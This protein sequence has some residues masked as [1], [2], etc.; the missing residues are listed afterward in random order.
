MGDAMERTMKYNTKTE[1]AVKNALLGLLAKKPLSDVTVSELARAAGVSRS[2][3]YEHYGNPCDVYDDLM[4]EMSGELSPLM[5][6]VTCKDGFKAEGTP[7]CELVRGEGRYA[8]VVG[9]ARFIDT[10]LGQ[11]VAGEGHDLYG[12]LVDA[13]YSCEQAEAVCSFQMSGCF[14]AARKARAAD[15]DWSQIRPVIDRF[16]LG[17]I[18]ACL[19]AKRSS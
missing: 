13:G 17:G 4:R 6:Q 5:S 16:I 18:A 3:F 7:F 15:A 9:D 14:N 8:P 2:T 19:A 10:L 11:Q 12:L 1:S